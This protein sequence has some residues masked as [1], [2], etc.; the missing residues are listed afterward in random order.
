MNW[1][2]HRGYGAFLL[3]LGTISVA[4]GAC[5]MASDLG[6]EA[7]GCDINT[8]GSSPACTSQPGGGGAGTTSSGVGGTTSGMA[9]GGGGG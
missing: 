7:T 6:A 5:S 1:K 3:G 2:F 8:G 9:G 4:I